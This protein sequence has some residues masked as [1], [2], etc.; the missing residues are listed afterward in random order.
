LENLHAAANKAY[1]AIQAMEAQ[2]TITRRK[3]VGSKEVIA[4]SRH[5]IRMIDEYSG[6]EPE[7]YVIEPKKR[8]PR[9]P[10]ERI[11]LTDEAPAEAIDL[12]P[13]ERID[14]AAPK[15]VDQEPVQKALAKKRAAELQQE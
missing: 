9:I 13:A 12:T 7:A 1:A 2:A 15:A 4:S 11:R 5:I 10:D 8:T 3:S 6:A 14:K